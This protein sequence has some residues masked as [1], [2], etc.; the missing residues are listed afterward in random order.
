[1]DINAGRQYAIRKYVVGDPVAEKPVW[2]DEKPM[3]N[4]VKIWNPLLFDEEKWQRRKLKDDRKDNRKPIM[5]M[6][7]QTMTMKMTRP[8]GYDVVKKI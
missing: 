2:K 5:K 4:S 3:L 1:M 6:D 8:G 7:R